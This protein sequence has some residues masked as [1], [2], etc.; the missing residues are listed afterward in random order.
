MHAANVPVS[1]T[2][3]F[4][5]AQSEANTPN[6]RPTSPVAYSLEG[7]PRV[8]DED[9]PESDQQPQEVIGGDGSGDRSSAHGTFPK[10]TPQPHRPSAFD[11]GPQVDPARLLSP[12][13][14]DVPGQLQDSYLSTEGSTHRGSA[15]P[16]SPLP[17]YPTTQPTFTSLPHHGQRRTQ[18][19]GSRLVAS[20]SRS[21]VAEGPPDVGLEAIFGLEPL[22]YSEAVSLLTPASQFRADDNPTQHL[23]DVP[24]VSHGEHPNAGVPDFVFMDDAL[25][26]WPDTSQ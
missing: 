23:A 24:A 3:A 26:M 13:M 9:G 14:F 17:G 22:G 8:E 18:Q 11:Y 4:N 15:G 21:D 10:S 2:G 19:S 12:S 20:G 1:V 6:K 25:S 5:E 16:A 7:P